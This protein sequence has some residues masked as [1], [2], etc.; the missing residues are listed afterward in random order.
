MMIGNC[1]CCKYFDSEK[2]ICFSDHEFCGFEYSDGYDV[3]DK[4][5]LKEGE[6]IRWIKKKQK[7][8][9][10]DLKTIQ[11]LDLFLQVT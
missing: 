6:D 11:K 3:D 8:L 5:V 7:K 10:K 1:Y 9:L 2:G 4:I